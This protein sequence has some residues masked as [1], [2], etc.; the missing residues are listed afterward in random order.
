M[1]ILGCLN[2]KLCAFKSNLLFQPGTSFSSAAN[3]RSFLSSK[4]ETW[5]WSCF[6]TSSH[7]SD[8]VHVSNVQA[9]A[10][11]S[12][13][14]D[15]HICLVNFLGVDPNGWSTQNRACCSTQVVSIC[16]PLNVDCKDSKFGEMSRQY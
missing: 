12:Y 15:D 2:F 10:N 8:D 16:K 1:Y 6:S 5:K 13:Q 14:N 9:T 4:V 11:K 7:P 3:N